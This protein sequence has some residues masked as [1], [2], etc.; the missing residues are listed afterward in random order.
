MLVKY[1]QQE[2]NDN[3]FVKFN[4]HGGYKKASKTTYRVINTMPLNVQK[5]ITTSFGCVKAGDI[6]YTPVTNIVAYLCVSF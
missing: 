4:K 5:G 1:N 6:I 2:K 3:S